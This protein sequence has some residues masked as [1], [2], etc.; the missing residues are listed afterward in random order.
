MK[1]SLLP[2]LTALAILSLSSCIN[3]DVA[4]NGSVRPIPSVERLEMGTHLSGQQTPTIRFTLRNPSDKILSLSDI[5]VEGDFAEYYRLNVD[6]IGGAVHHDVE[7]R[8]NDSI[9]IL[10]D[11]EAVSSS[12]N[13]ASTAIAFTSSNGSTTRLP[14]SINVVDVEVHKDLHLSSDT[15]WEGNVHLYGT[16]RIDEGVTLTI[17]SGSTIY[18]HDSAI[19]DNYGQ[20][21][22]EGTSEAPIIM[23]GDRHGCVA[24]DIPY[25]VMSRQWSGILFR[26]TSDSNALTNVEIVNTVNAIEMEQGSRLALTNCVISNAS[27]NVLRC[28]DASVDA[29]GCEFSNAGEGLIM[30]DGGECN[31]N[32]C[33]LAN[34]YLLAYCTDAAI[35]VENPERV[36]MNIDNCLI[37][38]RWGSELSMSDLTGTDILFRSTAMK[39]GG[40][41]DENFI[42]CL[43]ESPMDFVNT[44][45][46]YLFD[47]SLVPES[48]LHGQAESS[49]QKAEW[50]SDRHGNVYSATPGA[51][52]RCQ[53]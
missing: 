48:N 3:D 42:G 13:T 25:D 38:G 31:L 18:L 35:S 23:R 52:Q 45:E 50:Q 20:I 1:K 36:K 5:R 28:M 11:A 2:I 4:V 10:V 22:A 7:I 21:S 16:T 6:G 26:N 46:D 43:W 41:D 49:L 27:E 33:T 15:K 40:N 29:V 34:Y 12:L 32:H 53:R 51:Y 14:L 9:Y 8:G 39:S 47:F 37:Y 19:I 44:G 24:A 17:S 30:I